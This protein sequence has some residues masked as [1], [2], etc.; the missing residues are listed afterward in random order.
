MTPKRVL[1]QQFGHFPC[2][3]QYQ[4]PPRRDPP[5]IP[6]QKSGLSQNLAQNLDQIRFGFTQLRHRGAE[7]GFSRIRYQCLHNSPTPHFSYYQCVQSR[8]LKT[9]S[10]WG[11]AGKFPRLHTLQP[12]CDIS[13]CKATAPQLPYPAQEDNFRP[14]VTNPGREEPA[15]SG[16]IMLEQLH[17]YGKWQYPVSTILR[18]GAEVPRRWVPR[19]PFPGA[20]DSGFAVLFGGIWRKVLPERVSV[21]FAVGI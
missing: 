17:I 5:P 11:A 21:R 6:S 16:K 19:S 3:N 4:G 18:R 2:Q 10:L 7:M 14:K 20:W 12:P 1:A 15:A 8:S 9:K 13:L